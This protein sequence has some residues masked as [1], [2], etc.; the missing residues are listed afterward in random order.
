M[1]GGDREARMS[2]RFRLLVGWT[3]GGAVFP[4]NDGY[5]GLRVRQDIASAR[6]HAA[7]AP[8]RQGKHAKYM[9]PTVHFPRRRFRR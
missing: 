4:E 9:F 6:E 3:A 8:S 2:V 7:S 1:S 5:V